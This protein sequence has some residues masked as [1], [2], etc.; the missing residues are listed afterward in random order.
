MINELKMHKTILY[1]L[2]CI[3]LVLIGLWYIISYTNKP[4]TTTI[5]G[6]YFDTYITIKIDD[7]IT[8][9]SQKGLLN[10]V[11]SYDTILSP[12]LEDSL[13]F[14]INKDR[15]F[16][17][18]EETKKLIYTSMEISSETDGIVDPTIMSVYE[19]YDFSP[20]NTSSPDIRDIEN[21]LANVDY[22]S[23]KL[24]N[25]RLYI[26]NNDSKITFGF[27]AKG[28]ISDEIR[29]YLLDSGINNALINLGG[30][31]LAIGDN[32]GDNYKIAIQNPFKSLP[33]N[34]YDDYEYTAETSKLIDSLD[35]TSLCQIQ[36]EDYAYTLNI[37]NKSVVTSGLY[38][39][40]Y[41][42]DGNVMHH[43]LDS[44]SGLP[45]NN[46]LVSVSII[47]PSST[48]CDAY[49]TACF[50]MGLEKGLEYIDSKPEYQA[51]F[52]TKKQD[53]IFSK[54]N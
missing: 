52:I 35:S 12:Y 49:S 2:I 24:D 31:V 38:E 34:T 53:I 26:D 21:A 11:C 22:S 45:V 15:E 39:R 10:L 7:N 36:N 8:P 48:Y 20:E 6:F 17:V 16:Y 51:I 14:K 5:N 32:H 33:S 40:Y 3:I 29:D 37:S 4:A 42:D 9:N 23:I 43:L 47:G 25:N 41:I 44:S 46:E 19:L 28:F 27:I 18:T 1:R 50:L 54:A 13:C 30:N